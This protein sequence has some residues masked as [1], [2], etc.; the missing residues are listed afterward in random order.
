MEDEGS[1]HDVEGE[2]SEHEVEDE[3]S[4]NEVGV[5]DVSMRW[6]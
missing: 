6:G 1:E 4:D 3:G 5:R 2:V